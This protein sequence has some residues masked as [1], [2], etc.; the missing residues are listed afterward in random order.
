MATLFSQPP[1]PPL[2]DN[3]QSREHT[4]QRPANEGTPIFGAGRGTGRSY[5]GTVQ[6]TDRPLQS[7]NSAR[8]VVGSISP[9]RSNLGARSS[10]TGPKRRHTDKGKKRMVSEEI[11]DNEEAGGR[12]W[13]DLLEKYGSVE[14]DNKGSVARDHL[15]L[16][17]TSPNLAHIYYRRYLF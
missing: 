10:P 5:S 11:D 4:Q 9:K 17:T 1:P 14:L 6:Q 15:A 16:G 8:D 7:K 3:L 12:W 13:K 2:K